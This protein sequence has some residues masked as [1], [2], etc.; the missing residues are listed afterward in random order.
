M[1]RSFLILSFVACTICVWADM[2]DQQYFSDAS[3]IQ[4]EKPGTLSKALGKNIESIISLQINGDMSD[5]DMKSLAKFTNLKKLSL[6]HANIENTKYFPTL[7]SLEV[8]FLPENQHLPIEYMSMVPSNE[9]LR[10]MM[11]CSFL[12]RQADVNSSSKGS[13]PAGT[14]VRFSPFK[15]LKKVIITDMLP[16]QTMDYKNYGVATGDRIASGENDFILVD[17][18]VYIFNRKEYAKQNSP[19]TTGKHVSVNYKQQFRGN[20]EEEDGF[21]FYV[22]N[23][24]VDFS[25]V[26]AVRKPEIL[27]WWENN[28]HGGKT[29]EEHLMRPVVPSTL[30]LKM[31]KYI[32][33]G[34]F[35]D[36]E[37]E[38]INFS[39]TFVQLQD[40]AFKGTKQLKRINFTNS[41]SN[42]IIPKQCFSDCSNLESILFDCPA[43]LEGLAF[44]FDNNIKEIT[45]NKYA[46]I[47]SKAFLVETN[48]SS[49]SSIHKVIFNAPVDI[50]SEGLMYVDTIVFNATPINLAS[51]FSKCHNIIIPKNKSER[52]ISW[53][54]NSEYLIDP[55]ADLTLD[56][57]VTEPGNI[58]KYLP[59]DKLT[60]ITSLTVTGHLYET[61]LAIIKQCV[62]LQY[63]NLADTYI[64]ESPTSQERREAENKM[65]QDL[66]ELST[67]DAVIKLETGQS[68][69][70]EA[71]QQ[72]AAAVNAAA[73]MQQED[74]PECYIPAAAFENM[75]LKEVVLPKT[76]KKIYASAFSGCKSLTKIDLG[77]NLESIGR[78]AFAETILEEISFPVTL[79]EIEGNAFNKVS[80]L[81]VI[82]LSNCHMEKLFSA[83]GGIEVNAEI[84]CMP[85]LE[86]VYMPQGMTTFSPFVNMDCSGL[87]N[88]YV[89]KDVK[90]MNASLNNMNLH[91]QSEMAP[92]LN[93]F[94]HFEEI[95]NC[96]IYVPKDGNITSYYAKFNGNGN[97][98]IQE[99]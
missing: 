76:L 2:Y 88:V 43:I 41:L 68:N 36:T 80:T 66:A 97:K 67:I 17:T 13:H 74:M 65:W 11:F 82:D 91:F 6:R 94:S 5:K 63:L 42:V 54:I 52:F 64:S 12:D 96:T 84:G 59:I 53:G 55:F 28:S 78:G 72:M 25:T 22:G 1:K 75:R 90:V 29:Y 9:N 48:H 70:R 24:N 45:F 18:I 71:K 87:K 3:F 60:Q 49:N 61:D 10:V 23:E 51:D 14:Y 95:K 15:S 4:L 93:S 98:I 57:I 21:I 27:K 31:M 44:S 50:E 89:G 37:V 16:E 77:E 8:L 58:L 40:Q 33:S 62:N 30:D 73:M 35:N 39:S 86:T 99:N 47:N 69:K 79:K 81:K 20:Y 32:G 7:P 19:K 56:I 83:I 26:Q 85:N 92:E 34:Y 46:K 38:D